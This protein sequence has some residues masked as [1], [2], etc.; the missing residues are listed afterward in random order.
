MKQ[1]EF[2][3]EKENISLLI[4]AAYGSDTRPHPQ[5]REQTYTIL[6]IHSQRRFPV[7]EFPDVA[8]GALG[9]ILFAVLICF[10]IQTTLTGVSIFAN[11]SLLI[12]AIWLFLNLILLP[13]AG[14]VIVIRR[15]Y[16]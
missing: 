5:V 10:I 13:V 4:Q 16:G 9:I 6:K 1:E 11:P 7:D 14:A 8:V 12:M 2:E 15:Q 3:I